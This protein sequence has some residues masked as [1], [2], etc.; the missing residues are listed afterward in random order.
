MGRSMRFQV[1]R[2]LEA[3]SGFNVVA[4]VGERIGLCKKNNRDILA[5]KP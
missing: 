1:S 5:V 4:K 2:L 3:V